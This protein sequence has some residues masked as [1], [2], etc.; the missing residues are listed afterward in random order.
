MANR[1]ILVL[2]L[3]TIPSPQSLNHSGK[4]VNQ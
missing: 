2:S 1:N 3:Q 4:R